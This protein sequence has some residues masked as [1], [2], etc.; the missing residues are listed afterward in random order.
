MCNKYTFNSDQP[1]NQFLEHL[2]RWGKKGST[3]RE[4]NSG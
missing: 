4:H 3:S 1:G 2:A